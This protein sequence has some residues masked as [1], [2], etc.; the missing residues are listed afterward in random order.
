MLQVSTEITLMKQVTTYIHTV[1]LIL[2]H[3]ISEW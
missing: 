2:V 1:S 3:Y